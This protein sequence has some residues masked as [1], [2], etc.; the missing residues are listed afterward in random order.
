MGYLSLSRLGYKKDWKDPEGTSLTQ[1]TGCK[2]PT[3]AHHS[4]SPNPNRQLVKEAPVITPTAS[5][6]ARIVTQI[7]AVM[8]L[9]QRP[10][11]AGMPPAGCGSIFPTKRGQNA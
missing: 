10:T 4:A 9:S 5:V 7:T 11:T 2:S 3:T 8:R 6:R 1:G